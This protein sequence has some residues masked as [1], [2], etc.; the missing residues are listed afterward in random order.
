[1]K[2]GIYGDSFGCLNLNLNDP[3]QISWPKLLIDAGHQVI[4]HSI[5][6]STYS[7]NFKQ[8]HKFK[9]RY[10]INIV[11]ITT[12]GRLEIS[13]IPYN[14]KFFTCKEDAKLYRKYQ[15]PQVSNEHR[16]WVSDLLDYIE[17]H[18][19]HSIGFDYE[20][21]VRTALTEQAR[22][23]SG[24]NIF[25]GCF[26]DV[27]PESPCL[28]DI[29]NFENI[30]LDYENVFPDRGANLSKIV[31]GKYLVDLRVCHLTEENHHLIAEKILSA[32]KNKSQTLDLKINEFRKPSK[33][34]MNYFQVMDA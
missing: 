25:I 20:L 4:N 10:D 28:F 2:I 17:T 1:M 31:N 18:F 15:L 24:Q 6:G 30:A 34:I 27:I 23:A 12:L 14:K 21:I 8:F 5:V 7:Y 19:E 32:I 26:D 11:L 33:D 3:N 9:D 29:F 16:H 13:K 22:R